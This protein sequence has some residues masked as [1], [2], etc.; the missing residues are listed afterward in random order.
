MRCDKEGSGLFESSN[1]LDLFGHNDTRVD[2]GMKTIILNGRQDDFQIE[3]DDF[4]PYLIRALK[5]MNLHL[6]SFVK[7]IIDRARIVTK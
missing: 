7:N 4:K 5:L 2:N 6:Q 1:I 3:K